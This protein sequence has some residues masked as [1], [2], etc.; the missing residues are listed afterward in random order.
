MVGRSVGQ[1]SVVLI[2][3][4]SPRFGEER[5]DR[6]IRENMR[7]MSKSCRPIFSANFHVPTF[8][9]VSVSLPHV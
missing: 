6:E 5:E 4:E 9:H 2:K 3:P 7:I 8:H 1:Y